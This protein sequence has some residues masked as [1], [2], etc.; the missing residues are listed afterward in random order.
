MFVSPSAIERALLFQS[1][2]I[3]LSFRAGLMRVSQSALGRALSSSIHSFI[4]PSFRVRQ[5]VEHG[6][7][8]RSRPPGNTANPRSGL[9]LLDHFWTEDDFRWYRNGPCQAL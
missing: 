8:R 3:A 2:V 9:R 7:C 6:A 4:E 1:H 5:P